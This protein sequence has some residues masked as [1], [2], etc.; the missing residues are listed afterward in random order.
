MISWSGK[1]WIWLHEDV[2]WIQTRKS[3]VLIPHKDRMRT[4]CSL[5]SAR[6]DSHTG[7]CLSLRD[8]VHKAF[9]TTSRHV[10]AFTRNNNLPLTFNPQSQM[11]IWTKFEAIVKKACLQ[12]RD[13]Q[14]L[15]NTTPLSTGYL[16]VPR[17]VKKLSQWQTTEPM[18]V[19]CLF[20]VI[21]HWNFILSLD[22]LILNGYSLVLWVCPEL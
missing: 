4:S 19:K 21:T 9:I 17:V 12:E 7:G 3:E 10:D 14:R 16:Q 13:G 6:S 18:P 1:N 11:N 22:N 20:S 15:E 5:S 8:Q 2:K